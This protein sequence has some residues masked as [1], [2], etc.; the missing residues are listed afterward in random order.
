M[1][2]KVD[3]GSHAWRIAARQTRRRPSDAYF[4]APQIIT[5]RIRLEELL[6]GCRDLL[7]AHA[8]HLGVDIPALPARQGKRAMRVVQHDPVKDAYRVIVA[9]IEELQAMG[10]RSA[11]RI[12]PR[13]ASAERRRPIQGR[14]P[15]VP[16]ARAVI[17]VWRTEVIPHPFSVLSQPSGF[18][19]QGAFSW[20]LPTLP[21]GP[22]ALV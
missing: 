3:L 14:R 21:R 8:D 17:E 19:C 9:A 10:G 13:R 16:A 1:T 22:I 18:P 20:T 11:R 4:T 5:T 12:T 15:G 7:D 6:V 2:L